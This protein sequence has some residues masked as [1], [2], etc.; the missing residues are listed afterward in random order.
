MCGT[1]NG[2]PPA[3]TGVAERRAAEVVGDRT[4]GVRLSLASR[5]ASTAASNCAESNAG[6]R[7]KA[8]RSE[9]DDDATIPYARCIASM[10]TPATA[11]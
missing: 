11:Q 1:A 8:S 9:D 7:W 5:W 4:G 2:W 10:T 6:R 3:R